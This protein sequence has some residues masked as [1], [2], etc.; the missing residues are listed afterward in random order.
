MTTEGYPILYGNEGFSYYRRGNR[1][2]F[3][4]R[5]VPV[6]LTPIVGTIRQEDTGWYSIEIEEWSSRNLVN[7]EH[8]MKLLAAVESGKRWRRKNL[9]RDW[10][11]ALDGQM[12]PACYAFMLY[13]NDFHATDYEVEEPKLSISLDELSKALQQGIEI[14]TE[15]VTQDGSYRHR[16]SEDLVWKRDTVVVEYEKIWTILKDLVGKK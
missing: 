1:C 9:N 15:Y 7:K 11:A 12:D 2:Y 14:K 13:G 3:T 16:P 6:G 10:N 4:G 5:T 8:G